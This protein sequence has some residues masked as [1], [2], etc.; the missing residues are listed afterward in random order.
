MKFKSTR[1]KAPVLNFSEALRVGLA[2]DG[3]LYIPET[4]P[5]FEM[6][7]FSKNTSF[8]KIAETLLL[9]FLSE[10]PLESSISEMIQNALNFPI[11]IVKLDETTSVLELFHGPTAAFKD[12]GARF[13]AECLERISEKKKWTILVAT[14]GDTGSAVAAAFHGKTNVEVFILYP[15]GLVSPFQEEQ[16]TSWGDN[17][18]AFTVAGTFD[19]CQKIVKEAFADSRWKN[20]KNLISANSINIGR[21]LPQA[22]YYASTS[23]NYYNETGKNTRIHNTIGKCREFIGSSLG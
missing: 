4:F 20:N 3:G 15:K 1:G 19:D 21:I 23:I 5:V 8:Q 6:K 13:L 22:V 17:V 12:V 2:S 16:L 18:R 9:P 11:P 14:S 7:N 10:D